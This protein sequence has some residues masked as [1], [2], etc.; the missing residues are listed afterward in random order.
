MGTLAA[1][2]VLILTLG[3]VATYRTLDSSSPLATA[4]ASEPPMVA[5]VL[6]D[7]VPA[8][9]W[10]S[11]D[12]RDLHTVV[13]WE[14]WS[15]EPARDHRKEVFMKNKLIAALVLTAALAGSAIAQE[16][17]RGTLVAAPGSGAPPRAHAR[18]AAEARFRLLRR[19]RTH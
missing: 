3:G 10:Q 8:D 18:A 2:A 13:D 7:D 12:L 15:D 6:A 17:P 5:I 11:E 9:P 1:A 16:M 19:P 14:S 4:A